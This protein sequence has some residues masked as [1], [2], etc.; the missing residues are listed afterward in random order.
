MIPVTI[1]L[2][3]EGKRKKEYILWNLYE[4]YLTPE[5]YTHLLIDENPLYSS[6]ELL[7]PQSIK[8]AIEA[9]LIL[10][11]TEVALGINMV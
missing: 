5:E 6:Y 10:Q 7:I 9:Y 2:E 11:E 3:I 1:E 4:P 8:K